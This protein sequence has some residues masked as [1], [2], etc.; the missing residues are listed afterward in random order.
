MEKTTAIQFS[1]TEP[2]SVVM[3]VLFDPDLHP[4]LNP[5]PVMAKTFS[6]KIKHFIKILLFFGVEHVGNLNITVNFPGH[7]GSLKHAF[8]IL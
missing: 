5:I 6:L 7:S 8:I 3:C 2:S 1:D 4:N